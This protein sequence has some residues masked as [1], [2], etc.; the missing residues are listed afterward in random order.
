MAVLEGGIPE[1]LEN[2]PDIEAG[3]GQEVPEIPGPRSFAILQDDGS[4]DFGYTIGTLDLDF[5]EG[6][7]S[8]EI[9]AIAVIDGKLL[10]AVPE[11]VWSRSVQKRRLGSRA[12]AK[13]NLVAV[14]SCF[15]DAREAE[16]DINCGAASSL[17]W[18]S[19]SRVGEESGV[20]WSWRCR[21]PFWGARR[22]ASCTIWP[23]IGGGGQRPLQLHD[24]RVRSSF[25]W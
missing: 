22:S 15:E 10:V 23:C 13:P 1:P 2:N 7:K 6:D 21:L 5:T 20:H 17:G 9:A 4:L 18:L 12:L 14:A 3:S 16:E 19:S 24:C 11:T 8:C 25:E